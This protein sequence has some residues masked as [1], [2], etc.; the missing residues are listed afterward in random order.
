MAS[1][2]QLRYYLKRV[3]ADLDDAN[4]RLREH[5]ARENDPVAIV[6]MACRYP[7]GAT[8]P[9]E[10][11]NLVDTGR[12]AIAGFPTDRGW[13]LEGLYHPDPDHPGT[14]YSAEGGFLYDAGDFDAPFF[15]ISPA[16][17]TAMDPQQRLTLETS[18]EALENAGIDPESLRASRTGVFAAQVYHDYA[19]LVAADEQALG[20]LHTGNA[21]SV[22]SGRIAYCLGLEGPAVSVDTA[23]SSSLVALHLA[24]QSLR[25]G[26]C[27]LALAG[28][29]TVLATPGLFV[30]FSKQRALAADGRS[31]AFSDAADGTGFSEGVGM[32]VL[33]RLSDA[34]RNGH[35]VFAL[36]RGSAV[37]SDGASNGLTAPN[38]RSQQ[39]VIGQALANARVSAD[40]V[41]VVEAHGTGTAL[42]DPIEAQ[43]LLATYG[44]DRD[45]PVKLGS[46]K[47]NIGH[48]QAAAG[49]AGVIKMVQALRH[50]SLPK[51]L[52]VAQPSG[53]V[54]W[55][56]GSV[57]LLTSARPWPAAAGPRR[58]AVSSFGISG[59]NAHVILEQAPQDDPADPAAGG[60]VPARAA[61]ATVPCPLSAKTGAALRDQA[62]RLHDHLTANPALALTDVCR[63]LAT[64]RPALEHRAALLAKDRGELLTAL[65]GF[66]GGNPPEGTVQ[67]R[68]RTARKV[69]FVFPGQGT[70]WHGMAAGLL[71]TNAVFAKRAEECAAAIDPLVDW[72][73]LDVL[74]GAPDA[75]PLDRIDVV[76]PALF[77]TMVALAAVWQEHGVTPAAVVGHSQGEIAAACVAGGLTLAD[78]AR[79]V[80]GR[81]RLWRKAEVDGCGGMLLVA[82]PAGEVAQAIAPWGELLAI[83]SENGPQTTTVSG[84]SDAL[85]ELAAELA[86]QDIGNRIIRGISV[87]GHSPQ[88]DHVREELL[89]TLAP[90]A[91]HASAVPL[92]STV[93]GDLLAT[94]DMDAPYWW[95]NTRDPVLF[96]QAVRNALGNGV[97]GVVEVSPHPAL[98]GSVE[99]IAQDAGTRIA[100]TATLR[101]GAGGAEGLI[102]AL[103]EA[104]TRGIA[105][106]WTSFLPAGPAAYV[107]L[108]TYAF[109]RERYWPAPAPA[110]APAAGAA[111]AGTADAWRYRIRWSR[112]AA[113]GDAALSGRWLLVGTGR[114][115]ERA[116]A[117]AMARRGATVDITGPDRIGVS[118][119]GQADPADLAGVVSLLALDP[120][121]GLAATVALVNDLA[122]AGTAAPVWCVTRG[123]VS[124]SGDDPVGDCVPA[125]VWGFGR[126]AAL[127]HPEL[128]GGLVDL[129]EP[130]TEQALDLMCAAI[131]AGG[132]D[133]I[134]VRGS[135]VLARRLVRAAVPAAPQRRWRPR[136]TVLV[137]GGLSGVGSLIARWLARCGAQRLVLA[138]R[139]GP[140]TP[141]AAEL[142]AELRAQGSDVRMVACDV[143]DRAAVAD[144]LAT[145]EVHSVFH[146]A[147]ALTT[148]A[149]ADIDPAHLEELLAAKA[150]GAMHLHERL[151][152]TEL[153]A[154]VLLSSGAGVWGA[155]GQGAYAAANAQLDALAEHRRSR[156]LPATSVA[157]GAW[158]GAGT[159]TA[160]DG[161]AEFMRRRGQRM[162]DPDTALSAL[163]GALDNG[164]TALVVAD[165]DWELF[166]PTFTIGRA[167]PL[168]A[169]LPE[170]RAQLHTAPQRSAAE[171]AA[172][173][174]D[175]VLRKAEQVMGFSA[176]GKLD[177]EQNLAEAGFDSLMSI[178]L[179]NA[180]AEET[181]LELP[182]NLAF[183][184]PTAAAVAAHVA[185]RLQPAAAGPGTSGGA[186]PGGPD[187]LYAFFRSAWE[188]NRTG[189]GYKLMLDAA[190]LR[191]KFRAGEAAKNRVDPVKL[192]R[193][194]AEPVL[195]L[196]S[197]FVAI[198]GVHEYVRL[199]SY[200]RGDR[201]AAVI[202]PPGFESEHGLPADVGVFLDAQAEA[203]LEYAAGRPFVLAGLSSGGTMAHA[204]AERLESGGHT[205]AGVA[206]LDVYF[207]AGDIVTLFEADLDAGMFA[208]EDTWNP[209]TTAR[210]TTAAWYLEMFGEW[211]PPAVAAPTLLLRATEPF[212]TPAGTPGRVSPG[213]ADWQ[214]YWNLP[215]TAVDVPGNHFTIVEEHAAD[216]AR[217]MGE[218]MRSLP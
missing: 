202:Q 126:V 172:D 2:E 104:W 67:A 78:G 205:V 143:G 60:A 92:Y 208:R 181:G 54:D 201:E 53:N 131:A 183:A 34:R 26:D 130:A 12:D 159:L 140:A 82:L 151:E 135:G 200:F 4:A 19:N 191:P 109:Q 139:R 141:G 59:T 129:P 158:G 157:W 80:V 5:E 207:H 118:D 213:A 77:T 193:G 84:E 30:A 192:S 107:P 83:A 69:M 33:E 22:L 121:H 90:V 182:A 13:D 144:L 175:L 45:R 96:H 216:S 47:S 75:A 204:V 179:R 147:G 35:P 161:A 170:A 116:A 81:S 49:A 18:W 7:G 38:G 124:A 115:E 94:S 154:F 93:T 165:I 206:L 85:H 152:T 14:T 164:D 196:F 136:G 188:Q 71:E 39:R 9:D 20:H 137:T 11:W 16:E 91:P 160:D 28:G 3:V 198:G 209:M 106:D 187:T 52:H 15:G 61:P 6:G 217:A 44:R 177:P 57:E 95:R 163:Q 114:P 162:M 203:V 41:E 210:L 168:L 156:G 169:D 214:A 133:Q 197:T 189:A 185:E 176:A 102:G 63:A 195:L 194:P 101:R 31:K 56:A 29:V 117:D 173:P 68:A 43:A 150:Q 98:L 149:V 87:A 113:P 128:W 32:L 46:I 167:A 64:Q 105:L 134:A 89:D 184:F 37:N 145:T 211:V 74:R 66:A 190:D 199:A 127:E 79:I 72:S 36:V 24:A 166:A 146:A 218:W 17:A 55:T 51:T 27:T 180:I 103:A 97:D 65:S 42:G 25:S 73:V 123:A 99:E 132:E 148:A 1:D 212:S 142:E 112:A 111:G 76:Q 58:A 100:A 88:V 125:R 122:A 62:A 70:Q 110:A 50:A 10:L 23:C 40:S 21:S 155:A 153:D 215:H 108:P 8:G 138:G 119:D 178:R 186:G 48:T 120:E 174:R 86:A 171:P